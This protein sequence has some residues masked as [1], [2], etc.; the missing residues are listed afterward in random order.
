MPGDTRVRLN[1]CC[2]RC[3]GI[4]AR[5]RPTCK[6][7]AYCA[8]C[9]SRYGAGRLAT[10]CAENQF[11]M[12]MAMPTGPGQD[13]ELLEAC[14]GAV[15]AADSLFHLARVSVKAAVNGA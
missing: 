9:R 6:L 13:A 2:G 3:T 1:A 4:K 5:L 12:R 11:C 15:A 8:R 7:A 10:C 14:R